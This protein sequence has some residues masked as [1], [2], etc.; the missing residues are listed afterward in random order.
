MR[1]PEL[2]AQLQRLGVHFWM[3]GERLRY[4]AP[5]GV[6]TQEMRTE[7]VSRKEDIMRFVRKAAQT[8]NT[9]TSPI[10]VALRDTPL[11]LSFAQQRLWFI[12]RLS[13][14]LSGYHIPVI[15]RLNGKLDVQALEQS[16]LTIINRH[17]LLRTTFHEVAGQPIQIIAPNA[18]WSQTIIDLSAYAAHVRETVARQQIIGVIR[19]PFDLS[20]GPLLRMLLIRL[21]PRDHVLV[22]TLHHIIVDAWSLDV[23]VRELTVCYTAFMRGEAVVL[24]DLPIQYGDFAV[25]QQQWL[26]S[27]TYQ[28]QRTYWKQQLVGLPPF[29]ELPTDYPRPPAQTFAGAHQRV[30]IEPTVR[31]RL[32]ALGQQEQC[33]AFMTLLAVFMTL[34]TRYTRQEDLAVGS[35][36]ANRDRTELAGLIGLFVN[37]LVLRAGFADRPDFRTMLR[38]IRATVLD[39][40]AHQ[41]L[42]FERLVEELQPPRDLSRTPLFQVM[43]VLQHAST[44]TYELPDLRLS[45]QGFDTETAKFDLMLS[46]VERADGLVSTFEYATDLF[47]H[48]T[49]TRMLGHFETLLTGIIAHPNRCINDLSLL[50]SAEQHQIVVDWNDTKQTFPATCVHHLFQHQVVQTP[51]TVAAVSDGIH[52]TYERLNQRA[53]QVAHYLK[54]QGVELDSR[55]GVYLDRSLEL[56]ISVLSILKAG[57]AYVPLDLHYPPERVAYMLDNAQAQMLLTQTD[58]ITAVT[59]TMHPQVVCLDTQWDAIELF[60]DTNPARRVVPDNLAYVIY[61]SG[62]TGTPKGVAMPHRALANLLLWQRNVLAAPARTLQ[63]TSPSFDVS[64]QEWF[65]TWCTGGTLIMISD[66][67]RRDPLA[68]TQFIHN[69]TIER[70]FVPFVALQQIAEIMDMQ[71]AFPEHLREVITAGEQLQTT[72]SLTSWFGHTS[73]TNLHNH[74]GPSET[75]VATAFAL[76]TD[77]NEWTS[78]PPIGCPISNTSVYACTTQMHPVPIGV[79][80]ELYLGGESLARGYLHRSGLTAERFVPNPFALS[81]GNPG[82]RLYKTGDLVRYQPDGVLEFLGRADHQVKVRGYRVEPGEIEVALVQHP[83]I[84]EAIVVVHKDAHGLTQL[85]AYVL[86]A[87][88]TAVSVSDLRSF[89]QSKLPSYMVPVAFA[90]CEAWPLTPS[91]KVDRQAL[92]MPEMLEITRQDTLV[93]PRDTLEWQ[94]VR[95]WETLLQRQPIGI[96]DDFFTLGGHSLLVARLMAQIQQQFGQSLPLSIIFQEATIEHIARIVRQKRGQHWTPIVDMRPT[97]NKSPFFCIHPG[98]GQVLCYLDLV[99]ALDANRPFYAFQAAGLD[100]QREPLMCVEDMATCYIDALQSIQPEGPYFLGGWS[101]GGVVAFEMAQQ[102]QS[103]GYEIAVLALID[104]WA[105]TPRHAVLDDDTVVLAWFVRDL[106]KILGQQITVSYEDLCNRTHDQQLQIVL[107]HMRATHILPDDIGLQQIGHYATVFTNNIRATNTYAPQPYAG[108]V[109][110]FRADEQPTDDGM[111]AWLGWRTYI[112]NEIT[113]STIPGN[114]YTM[115]KPPHVQLLS[116]QLDQCFEQA[117]STSWK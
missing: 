92:P 24:P 27:E 14:G 62:S 59:Q 16:F 56:L 36:I 22:L 32:M 111:D 89:V 80:G 74:Y 37:T 71:H 103:C 96:T 20:E 64:F 61:T 65:S 3:D 69:Q 47:D 15:V 79:P 45:L 108:N 31:D 41:T 49:I 30:V 11:P 57:A 100:G 55:V 18:L 77:I 107:E 88:T 44:T 105:P 116:K 84:C 5:K 104:S 35:P 90:F 87:Q 70:L 113:I 42:P 38:Q 102:L 46:C 28:Q 97:G 58:L 81:D 93:S 1:T 52:L 33:T 85:I 78:L 68:L 54:S 82:S 99:Q 95:I 60:A 98:S 75:H 86:S 94:L 23:L 12:E 115:V 109:A 50:T 63:F 21:D 8:P 4:T 10:L 51:D 7:L 67:T 53:N 101:F 117:D 6:I 110:L 72:P 19:Q 2:L 48:T 106:G 66:T 91:G 17:E 13:P 43:F 40:F 73:N 25:W 39:A 112:T 26:Q 76:P 29:L 83:A 114:H 9:T 34:L